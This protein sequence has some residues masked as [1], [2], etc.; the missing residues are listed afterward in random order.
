MQPIATYDQSVVEGFA[1]VFTGWSYQARIRSQRPSAPLQTRRCRCRAYAEQHS[2]LAK[3]LLDYPG[4]VQTELPPGQT[5]AQDL[6]GALDNVFNHPNVAPFVALR[7]IQRLVTSNPS[8]PMSRALRR[9]SRTTARADAV[10]W[11]PSF[12]R[13]CS[14]LRPTEPP[15]CERHHG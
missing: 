2:S 8:R 1:N 6:A 4:A 3:R 5:A 15:D 9:C 11:T 12:A 14:I 10:S 7:L 13:S